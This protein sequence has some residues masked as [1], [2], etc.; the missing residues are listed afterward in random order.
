MSRGV[1]HD[2]DNGSRAGP[3]AERRIWRVRY[4]G[5][6]DMRANAPTVI[7]SAVND[8]GEQT[9]AG[10]TTAGHVPDWS[11]SLAVRDANWP[12]ASHIAIGRLSDR[13]IDV[14]LRVHSGSTAR[15]AVAGFTL[16]RGRFRL[17]Y[18]GVPDAGRRQSGASCSLRLHKAVCPQAR[19]A[20]QKM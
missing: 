17:N 15:R 16:Y 12:D 8:P 11:I 7:A 2:F 4:R 20:R 13:R 3:G 18:D 10:Q 9:F 14:W 1:R 19:T 6:A 5:P